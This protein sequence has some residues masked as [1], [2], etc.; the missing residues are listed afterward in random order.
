MSIR[1]DRRFIGRS[2][3]LL[4]IVV[5]LFLG[6]RPAHAQASCSGVPNNSQG[7]VTWVPQW[8]E[9]FNATTAGPPD[10][11]VWAFD[12]GNS[13]FGNNEIETFCGPPGY[14]GNPSDCPTTFAAAT[15]NAYLDGN[16]HLI[17]QAI[18]STTA[19]KSNPPSL[20]PKMGFWVGG[21]RG[22]HLVACNGFAVAR[23]RKSKL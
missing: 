7:A 18:N 16:G 12:L 22:R 13:G 20:N 21:G 17:I 10:T 2:R 15:S 8:C 9:E 14:S 23:R 3:Y 5:L 6:S 11:T 19:A 4:A 1:M